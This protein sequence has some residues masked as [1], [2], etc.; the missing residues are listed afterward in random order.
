M[1]KRFITSPKK[2]V[3]YCRTTNQTDIL[4]SVV[5]FTSMGSKVTPIQ[6]LEACINPSMKSPPNDLYLRE[7]IVGCQP[8]KSRTEGATILRVENL[9][10]RILLRIARH[11]EVQGV[12]RYD[13]RDLRIV[14]IPWNN[15]T[16]PKAV[17][18]SA[19]NSNWQVRIQQPL[20]EGHELGQ[21]IRRS[22]SFQLL[23]IPSKSKRM[24]SAVG[25][26]LNVPKRNNI[27]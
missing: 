25:I 4:L 9:P 5:A 6:N 27:N 12:N 8:I 19:V 7:R 24:D 14:W 17:F 13:L 18:P 20:Q 10:N 15:P 16:T 21:K 22:V 1:F 3:W 2:P 26:V 23:T 11:L